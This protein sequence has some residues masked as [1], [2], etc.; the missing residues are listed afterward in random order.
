MMAIIAHKNEK[1]LFIVLSFWVFE[2]KKQAKQAL[3]AKHLPIGCK[4]R[5]S[6]GINNG[7]LP[8]FEK[9]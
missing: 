7:Q 3:P 8:G 4:N 1:L 2:L 6:A 5:K 9:F